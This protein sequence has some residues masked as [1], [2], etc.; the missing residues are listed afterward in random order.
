VTAAF[1][2]TQAL[3]T[4]VTMLRQPPRAEFM[5][6]LRLEL[7]V[8]GHSQ[9][10]QTAVA[11]LRRILDESMPGEFDLQIIDVLEHPQAAEES[12]IVATPTLIKRSP[13]P[14][15]RLLGDLSAS[16]AVRRGLGI[17]ESTPKKNEK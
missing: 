11:N 13:A 14:V 6:R 7:F 5:E 2:T 17:D 12:N 8:I 3:T 16:G 1:Q 10:S 4:F 15:S 9:R